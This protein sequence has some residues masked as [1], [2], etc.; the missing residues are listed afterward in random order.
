MWYNAPTML[1]ATDH[2]SNSRAKGLISLSMLSSHLLLVLP[3]D[4]FLSHCFGVFQTIFSF[5][6][7]FYI[8]HCATCTAHLVHFESGEQHVMRTLNIHFS[9]AA[10]CFVPVVLL[11]SSEPCPQTSMI[12][13]IEFGNLSERMLTLIL[14]RSR[15]GTVWFYTSTSNKRAARPKL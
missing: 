10:Y 3:N 12:W 5:H 6:F 9:A 7:V 2:L 1:P 14:R 13:E 15:T 11:I 4:L 8:C